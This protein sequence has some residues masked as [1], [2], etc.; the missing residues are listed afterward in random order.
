M[1][2]SQGDQALGPTSRP[3][4][5]VAALLTVAAAIR[6]LA[7]RG[8]LWL[9]E[10]WSLRT[11]LVAPSSWFVVTGV[12]HDN[13]H[14]LNTLYL[15]MFGDGASFVSYRLLAVISGVG[16]VALIGLAAKRSKPEAVAALVLA[17][18][19][20]PLILYASEARGYG[21]AMM[22][23][24]ASYVTFLR[25]R[26]PTLLVLFWTTVIL[27]LL[28][29]LTFVYVYLSLVLWSTF[30]PR[31]DQRPANRLAE[32]AR[33]HTV[34]TVAVL[35]LYWIDVRHM[36]ISGGPVY[37][38]G[39]VVRRFLA[40]ASGAPEQGFVSLLAILAFLLAFGVGLWHAKETS[41]HWLF[42]LGVTVLIPALVL[43]ATRPT[44]IY[45]RYFVLSLPFFYLGV[46]RGLAACWR[47]G[48]IGKP[49]YVLALA[50]FLWGNGARTAG[51]LTHGRGNYSEAVQF[52]A[53]ASSSSEILVGS[54]ND[55]WGRTLVGFYARS[56][57]AGLRMHYT[58]RS[59]WPRGGPEWLITQRAELDFQPPPQ[60]ED[61]Q[62]GAVFKLARTFRYGGTSGWHWFV[63]RNVGGEH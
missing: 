26:T 20:Y 35:L 11:A 28:S 60:L 14:I 5:A 53:E 25:G 30:L 44:F 34:P 47:F 29:H 48:R 16:L 4:W 63:Y 49:L 1:T 22:F 27:G 45:F 17:T 41:R 43:V 61:P 54:D 8:D 50:L 42:F 55:V 2:E 13:N 10:L 7:A 33:W 59:A 40:F 58:P 9:D 3:V 38:L 37:P 23:A 24:V 52:M 31:N 56:L 39:Q 12:H 15:R 57:P 36:T 62:S 19:S 6:L 32:L 51:L 21:P 18:F 46:A